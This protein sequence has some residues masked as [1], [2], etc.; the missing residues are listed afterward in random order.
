VIEHPYMDTAERGIC[1]VCDHAP[2]P[3]HGPANSERATYPRREDTDGRLVGGSLPDHR[4][5]DLRI[6]RYNA[7]RELLRRLEGAN[8]LWKDET[9]K[10]LGIDLVHDF[11]LRIEEAAFSWGEMAEAAR[12]LEEQ[13]KLDSATVEGVHSDE[14]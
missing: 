7:G 10:R 13:K 6:P 4:R 14:R 3:Q 9:G 11:I 12:H 8:R 2:H 1:D 5:N